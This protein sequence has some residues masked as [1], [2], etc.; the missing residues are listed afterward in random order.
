[1]EDPLTAHSALLILTPGHSQY[2]LFC[3]IWV[4][5][6]QASPRIEIRGPITNRLPRAW[7]QRARRPWSRPRQ[8]DARLCAN[9]LRHQEPL[10][11]TGG[12]VRQMEGA[13]PSAPVEMGNVAQSNRRRRSGALQAFTSPLSTYC[14]T[15]APA[16]VLTGARAV[17]VGRFDSGA[18]RPAHRQGATCA[19]RPR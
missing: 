9:R 7:Y 17:P 19:R 4:E 14:R 8:G 16:F 5:L 10:R 6:R 3:T 2:G 13:A 11:T 15:K 12:F 1:L 18:L